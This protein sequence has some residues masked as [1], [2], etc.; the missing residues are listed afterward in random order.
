MQAYTSSFLISGKFRR[1]LFAVY[2]NFISGCCY[3]IVFL[4]DQSQSIE[5][6]NIEGEVPNWEMLIAFTQAVVDDFVIG[7]NDTRVAAVLFGNIA[8]IQFTLD[9]YY[10]ADEIKDA[11]EDLVYKPENTNTTGGIWVTR[12]DVLTEGAGA[13]NDVSDVIVMVTDGKPNRDVDLLPDE[14]TKLR[15]Q[16]IRLIVIGIGE[17]NESFLETLV[18]SEDDSFYL[19]YFA[20]LSEIVQ[21]VT[22]TILGTL[23]TIQ[24]EITSEITT[25]VEEVITDRTSSSTHDATGTV[26]E[27][28]CMASLMCQNSIN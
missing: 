16:N 5:E 4:L 23:P 7:E 17:A 8:Q 19:E 3:D 20:A 22:Q 25:Q 10:T 26:T 2:N 11:L 6:S 13:R 14:I 24:L 12:N 15:E 21:T 28:E 27:G 9:E 1:N 18:E